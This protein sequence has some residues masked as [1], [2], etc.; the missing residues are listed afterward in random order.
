MNFH[1]LDVINTSKRCTNICF[2]SFFYKKAWLF[3]MNNQ[4]KNRICRFF[5]NQTVQL[6]IQ[7]PRKAAVLRIHN[8]KAQRL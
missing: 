3:F 2:S 6:F 4:V 8:I 5:G 7:F 1:W